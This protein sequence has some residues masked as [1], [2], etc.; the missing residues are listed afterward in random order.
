MNG[1][2]QQKLPHNYDPKGRLWRIESSTG[3]DNIHV[4]EGHG[5]AVSYSDLLMVL[6]SFFIIF[7]S[8]NDK[9]KE[10]PPSDVLQEFAFSLGAKGAKLIGH[11]GGAGG[12]GSGQGP[13]QGEGLGA[14]NGPGAGAGNGPGPGGNSATEGMKADGT[15]GGGL[16]TVSKT[17]ANNRV[18][19]DLGSA[20]TDALTDST[21]KVTVEVLPK[22]VVIKFSDEM[23]GP[24]K[25][26]LS[27][28]SKKALDVVVEIIATKKAD[29][30]VDVV[31]HTDNKPVTAVK[32]DIV[33]NN[34]ILSSLRASSAV[35]FF[36]EKGFSKSN[37]RATGVADAN[38]G[39]KTLSL[40]ISAR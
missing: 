7:F 19:R 24:R 20:L 15:G 27:E 5:W 4:D 23:Y 36:M 10:K 34:F 12:L 8:F 37:L 3:D 38:E 2:K 35:D 21:V 22:S 25:W 30:I 16:G 17:T 18:V 9:D 14:G 39:S 31:G 11:D 13:G 33:T 1:Q 29:L 28:K 32:G 6:M 26:K 40:Q